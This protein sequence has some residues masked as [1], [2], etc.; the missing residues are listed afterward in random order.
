MGRIRSERISLPLWWRLI[1]YT[2][3]FILFALQLAIFF[4]SII[5]YNDKTIYLGWTYFLSLAI[6]VISCLFVIRRNMN[7]NYKLIW[8]IL[9]LIF[10]I[11]FSTLYFINSICVKASKY[12]YKKHQYQL[13]AL[14]DFDTLEELKT[15]D[16]RAYNMVKSLKRSEPLALYKNIDVTYFKDALDKHKDMLEELKNAK[17]YIYMEYFIIS[18]GKLMDE[19]YKVLKEKG[20]EGIEIKIIYD[21]LGSKGFLNRKLIKSL[22]KIPNCSVESYARVALNLLVNYRDHRKI[23]IIDGYISYTGGDNLADEYIHKKERFGFWRDSC[24]KYYGRCIFSFTLFFSEMWYSSTKKVLKFIKRENEYKKYNEN[25]F[26]V[27]FGDGPLYTSHTAYDLFISM[28]SQATSS[29]YISTPYFIIDSAIIDLLAIKIRSG[30][31]VKILMPKIPDKKIPFYM[32]RAN[33]RELLTAGGGVY[34]YT[35]GFNHSKAVI[36]D[37][38]YA[39]I[40]TINIDYR[41][42]FLHYECGALVANSK[43]INKMS[44][45]FNDAINESEKIEYDKWRKRPFI[46]KIIAFIANIF[47]P[48]F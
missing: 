40:G 39:F 24:M 4:F 30:I 45:D 37:N 23:C 3:G 7:A 36:I 9:F 46:Q 31:D 29:I 33:Y 16:L 25:E 18:A 44:L 14:S 1:L 38:K 22:K 35:P 48:M 42:L 21:D 43:E 13:P 20:E 26:V 47:A 27:P 32:G 11:P 34:E 5:F 10:P 19:L 41:S 17:K 8:C 15:K 2:I 12:S 28:I 6:G